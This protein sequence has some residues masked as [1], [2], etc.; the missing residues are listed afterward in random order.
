MTPRP[1]LVVFDARPLFSLAELAGPHA[2]VTRRPLS[3]R[4]PVLRIPVDT[5]YNSVR[6]CF[7]NLEPS[8]SIMD[9]SNQ[10]DRYERAAGELVPVRAAG[11]R[12]ADLMQ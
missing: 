9:T 3:S 7:G 4:L 10:R 6:Q 5:L 1:V 12:A 8:E 11:S 2:N